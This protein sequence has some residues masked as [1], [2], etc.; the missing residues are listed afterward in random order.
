MLQ[1]AAQTIVPHTPSVLCVEAAAVVQD[2]FPKLHWRLPHS[3]WSGAIKSEAGRGPLS[4]S[5]PRRTKEHQRGSRRA[6]HTHTHT[7]ARN[8]NRHIPIE[9]AED[10]LRSAW[11]LRLQ[12]EAHARLA[13]VVPGDLLRR[14]SCQ[15]W[16]R[17]CGLIFATIAYRRRGSGGL[18]G[19]ETT[20]LEKGCTRPV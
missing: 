5:K 14:R 17:Q 2:V 16:P 19:L 20:C 12:H 18:D 7:R 1:C 11:G 8:W 13:A 3:M 4:V 9:A 10:S 15:Q 6:W